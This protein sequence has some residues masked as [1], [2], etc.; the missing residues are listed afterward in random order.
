MAGK[1]FGGFSKEGMS[2]L[3]RLKKNNERDWFFPRKDEYETLVKVP[4]SELIEE[5]GTRFRQSAPDLRFSPK[6]IYRIYRDVRFLKDK[7]PYKTHIAASFD[8]SSVK[9]GSAPGFFLSV[10]PAEVYFGGGL[11]MPDARQ[12]NRLR[13]A[14][15][16]K[17]DGLLDIL[18]TP[19]FKRTYGELKGEKLKRAPK[20]YLPDHDQIELLKHKQFYAFKE[21]E[22]AAALKAGFAKTIGDGIQDML[23]LMRWLRDHSV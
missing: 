9:G 6:G 18:A 2:F 8:F 16:Q 12:L 17:P 19:K 20:G 15:D 11:Y 14:I 4:M 13:W 23:P 21:L 1:K 5:L 3:R 22:P 10:S 7:T